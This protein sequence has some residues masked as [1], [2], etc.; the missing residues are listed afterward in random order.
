MFQLLASPVAWGYCL[1]LLP[2]E[3]D[4]QGSPRCGYAGPK[5]SQHSQPEELAMLAIL[6]FFKWLGPLEIEAARRNGYAGEDR[7][8]FNRFRKMMTASAFGASGLWNLMNV[9]AF[10][11]TYGRHLMNVLSFCASDLWKL[12]N[13]S[14]F[15]TSGLWT[16]MNVSAVGLSGHSNSLN[17]SAFGLPCCLG[18]L[19]GAVAWGGR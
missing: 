11:A 19:P 17:V 8:I 6:F 9:S 13:V 1:G 14:A 4:E 3:E 16:L 2:G 5:K 7:D 15:R 18:L 12:M 10:R